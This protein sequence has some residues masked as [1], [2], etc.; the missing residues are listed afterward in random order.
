MTEK[1][2]ACLHN[3]IKR[4]RP[5]ANVL[6]ITNSAEIAV[7][8]DRR[9][10]EFASSKNAF[11]FFG[12]SLRQ[13]SKKK[14]DLIFIDNGDVDQ[15]Q[16]CIGSINKFGFLAI[17]GYGRATSHYAQNPDAPHTLEY[18]RDVIQPNRALDNFVYEHLRN[19]WPITNMVQT[20]IIF[21]K[22]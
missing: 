17:Y 22:R 14:F 1:E 7:P 15:V 3:L 6:F 8:K 2:Q 16:V 19:I 11:D 12:Y 20:L 5:K 9:D 10:I 18:V 4:I 13:K 21:E